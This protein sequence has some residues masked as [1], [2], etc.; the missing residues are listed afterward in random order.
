MSDLTG[1]TEDHCATACNKDGCVIGN[2]FRCAH[3]LKGGPPINR[4]NDP[5]MQAAYGEACAA[6]GVNNFLKTEPAT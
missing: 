6:I 4:L 5:A 3:P 1:L 2:S